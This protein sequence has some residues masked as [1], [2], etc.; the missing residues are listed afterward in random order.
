[1]REF[2]RKNKLPITGLASVELLGRLRDAPLLKPWGAI[3]FDQQRAKWGM[4]WGADTRAAAV[5]GAEASCGAG[6]CPVEVSFFGAT[7]AAFA[8][9]SSGWSIDARADVARATEAALA[10]CRKQGGECR[11]VA[12]VCADGS[13][14]LN[15]SR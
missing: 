13:H 15:A 2:E 3:V 5:S 1:M 4:A 11:V 7:C 14:R 6:G 12:S 10:D 9:S 8:H